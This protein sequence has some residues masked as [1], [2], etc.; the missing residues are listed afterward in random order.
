MGGDS[1]AA[2]GHRNGP[3]PMQVGQVG[4]SQGWGSGHHQCSGDEHKSHEDEA[5]WALRTKGSG[6]F[7]CG[8]PH[9]ARECPKKGGGKGKMGAEKG[10]GQGMNFGG[11][12][13]K[14]KGK[15]YSKGAGM[16]GGG[17][18]GKGPMYGSCWTC[19]GPHFAK[20]CPRG[21]PVSSLGQDG[22]EG[23]E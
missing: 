23:S 21:R 2:R 17:K 14:G 9:F 10:Y 5:A 19:G 1:G 11:Q 20:N 12:K 13:S 16:K 18:S 8:G 15:E 6:C 4:H 7:I 22:G 3:A